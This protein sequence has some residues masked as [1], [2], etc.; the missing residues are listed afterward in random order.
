MESKTVRSWSR[1]PAL[2]DHSARSSAAAIDQ[3][4]ASAG[5]VDELELVDEIVD[6]RVGGAMTIGAAVA[7]GAIVPIVPSIDSRPCAIVPHQGAPATEIHF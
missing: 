5:G 7:I 6:F 2:V 1:R 3:A 4:D